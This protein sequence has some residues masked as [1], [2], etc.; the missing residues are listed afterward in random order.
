MPWGFVGLAS[1]GE[2]KG[3]LP[4]GL[5]AQV[6]VLER[7]EAEWGRTGGKGWGEVPP[8]C[9]VAL[10][11]RDPSGGIHKASHFWA[12]SASAS[13]VAVTSGQVPSRIHI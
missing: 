9:S 3:F 8:A 7:R 1:L 4:G 5:Q 13:E 2:G 10:A 12:G 6:P 11:D